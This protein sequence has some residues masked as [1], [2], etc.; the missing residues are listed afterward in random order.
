MFKEI[1]SEKI[2]PEEINTVVNLNAAEFEQRLIADSNAVLIDVRTPIEHN[3]ARIPNSLLIDIYNPSFLQELDKLDRRKNYYLYCRSGN[4][5]Y[6][7]GMQMK[8]MGF[9]RV[10]NLQ[11]GIIGWS[12]SKEIS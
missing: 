11:P 10:F 5:S 12:G 1:Y 4:R 8:K 7:A 6:I 3:T 9:G 2:F